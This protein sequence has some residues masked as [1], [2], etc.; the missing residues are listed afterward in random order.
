M[1]L[2]AVGCVIAGLIIWNAWVMGNKENSG[3]A[4]LIIALVYSEHAIL[5]AGA[6]LV[7]ADYQVCANVEPPSLLRSPDSH[8]DY[9]SGQHFNDKGMA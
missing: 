4:A 8:I 9:H 3:I 1:V 2:R 7:R 5:N 6:P